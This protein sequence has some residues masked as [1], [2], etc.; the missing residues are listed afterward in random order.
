LPFEATALKTATTLVRAETAARY[1]VRSENHTI[2]TIRTGAELAE[3]GVMIELLKVD[4]SE[5][6]LL[7]W[8]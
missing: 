3:E 7:K 1:S 6:L 2:E 4:L 8:L 5:L